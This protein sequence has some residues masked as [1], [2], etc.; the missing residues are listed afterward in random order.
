VCVC[1]GEAVNGGF[2]LVLDGSDDAERRAKSVLSWDVN[3]GVR[4]SLTKPLLLAVADPGAKGHAYKLIKIIQ[5]IVAQNSV[6]CVPPHGFFGIQI[7]QNSNS[8]LQTDPLVGWDEDNPHIPHFSTPSA[9]RCL[10]RR[11]SVLSALRNGHWR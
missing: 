10:W 4:Y 5:P 8:L 1:R 7:L 3:N 2:G 11:S 9:S 6:K